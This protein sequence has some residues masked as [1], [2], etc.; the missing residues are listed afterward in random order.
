M[1]LADARVSLEVDENSAI[2]VSIE[3]HSKPIH[4]FWSSERIALL[5]L[6]ALTAM[7]FL[8]KG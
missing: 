5:D 8:L 2:T 6:V 4:V 3:R 1:S 7:H